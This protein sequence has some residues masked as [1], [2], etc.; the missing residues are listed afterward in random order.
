[1]TAELLTRHKRNIESFDLV[2]AGGGVFELSIDGDLIFSKK[3]LGRFP[4]DGEAE[5]LLQK[6][7]AKA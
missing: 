6:R 7:L 3:D 1:M 5:K 2:P 4:E